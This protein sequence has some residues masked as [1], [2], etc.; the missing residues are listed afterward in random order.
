MI[1]ENSKEPVLV[2]VC[3]ADFPK[4]FGYSGKTQ[5]AIT[6]AI[7]LRAIRCAVFYSDLDLEHVCC[8]IKIIVYFYVILQYVQW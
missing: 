3:G 8:S 6:C 5:K 1:R 4:S 2:T 7:R